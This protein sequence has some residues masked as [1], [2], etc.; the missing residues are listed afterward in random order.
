MLQVNKRIEDLLLLVARVC[1]R[2]P[3][4]P[5]LR[6]ACQK[7]KTTSSEALYRRVIRPVEVT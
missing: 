6:G 4:T 5:E 3:A 1:V 7:N 2:A